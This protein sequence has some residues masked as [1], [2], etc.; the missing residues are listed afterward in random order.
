[1]HSPQVRESLSRVLAEELPITQS[2]GIGVL[3]A[4]PDC[5]VLAL[6]LAANRN[7]KGTVF[8]GSLNAV[9]TL[10]GWS[11]LWVTLRDRGEVAHVVIQDATIRYLEP[12]RSDV[13]ATGLSPEATVLERA[14]EMLR[15]RGRARVSLAVMVLDREDRVVAEL[16]GRYVMHRRDD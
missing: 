7:H 14:V 16:A 10:A 6:P 8:A 15:R 5:V 2:L 1:M 11:L 9:A 13:R 3:E 12:A 4:S